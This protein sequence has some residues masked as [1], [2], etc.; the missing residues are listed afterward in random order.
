MADAPAQVPPQ[1]ECL[2]AT[3][4]N[5][6]DCEA[7]VIGDGG[8]WGRGPWACQ[9][10]GHAGQGVVGGGLRGV[11]CRQRRAGGALAALAC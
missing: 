6:G 4:G 1:R 10:S 8:A 7:G 3:R 11:C 5:P 2:H 9:D